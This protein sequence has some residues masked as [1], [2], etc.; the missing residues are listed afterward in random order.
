MP[1]TTVWLPGPLR[2][3]IE[4]TGADTEG[5]FCLLTDHPQP[6]WALPPHRHEHESETMYVIEGEFE[7]TVDGDTRRL[8]P[9]EVA[10]VPRGVTHSGR[11]LGDVTGRRAL[12]FAPAGIEDFF[13]AAA[14]TAPEDMLALATEHGWRFG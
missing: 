2:L 4:L 13:L 8:G 12:V 7:V 9:G 14:E 3:D 1:P 11:S 6:G 5:A 10:H